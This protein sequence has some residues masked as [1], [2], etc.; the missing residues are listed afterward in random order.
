MDLVTAL[1]VS[2]GVVF[3][4][5]LGDK[6]Q[7][8][9]LAYATKYRPVHVLA[10]ITIA[11]LVMHGLA[12]AVGSVAGAVIPERAV[13]IAAGVAFLVF[14]ALSLRVDDDEEADELAAK[15]SGHGAVA[16]VAASFVV[17]ELGDKT[18]LATLTLAGRSPGL[19][20]WLGAS[21]GMVA[22]NALAI[23]AGVA[24][25]KRLPAD[26]IRKG[27]AALFFVF[28]LLLLVDGLRG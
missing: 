3:V 6:S 21:L 18:Q 8:L 7:L 14:G 19:V 28:G 23:V 11:S 27:A 17:A 10:G 1:L 16:T 26:T 25:G 5:E 24:L 15:P 20:V 22:A 4:A 12:V 2:F 9:S 13:S